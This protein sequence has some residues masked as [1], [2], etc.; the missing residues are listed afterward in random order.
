MH[1]DPDQPSP[2][3]PVRPDWLSRHVED[4]LEP[5]RRI[6]DPHHHLWDRKAEGRYFLD[7]L[8]ADLSSGHNVVETVF[9]E[10]GAMYRAKGPDA[11]RSLGET[12]FANGVAA[13]SASGIYGQTAVCSG[14]VG[15]A[16]LRLGDNVTRVLEQHVAVAGNRFKGIR[17]ISAWHDDPAARGSLAAPP[18]G[19]LSDSQLRTG[20]QRLAAMGLSF[21]AYMYHTQIDELV[22]LANAVPEASIVLNHVGGVIGIGPYADQRDENFGQW[23]SS[24][25]ELARC[26]NVSVKIGGMGMRV[27]GFGFGDR[28]SPPTS[29]ELASAWA[30]YARTCINLFGASRCMFESN[31]PV[32]KG[33]CAYGVLWNA[34]KRI[35]SDASDSEKQDLFEDTARRVYRL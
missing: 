11:E 12:E 35:A 4:P 21:D 23:A 26:E 31:F 19:L 15:S 18:V 17:Q 22:D 20:L 25:A 34:F 14:I 8:L 29:T 30:P 2:H 13:M 10:C 3:Y 6:V 16:D 7:D 32:D 28:A 9:M 33:S 5:E 24:M 1:I 27:F